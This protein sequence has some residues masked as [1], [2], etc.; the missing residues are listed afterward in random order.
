M[1]I[2]YTV[3]NGVM[4]KNPANQLQTTFKYLIFVLFISAVSLAGQLANSTAMEIL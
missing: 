4:V 3:L 1:V 2:Y